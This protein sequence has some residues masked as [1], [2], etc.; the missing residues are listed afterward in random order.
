MDVFYLSPIDPIDIGFDER[1]E[2]VEF[3]ESHQQYCRHLTAAG[4]TATYSYFGDSH[5]Q[6][7]HP[8]GTH[9]VFEFPKTLELPYGF[10]LS[11]PLL[12]YL[13][14]RRPDIVHVHSLTAHSILP[15]VLV[16][17][18]LRLPLVLQHHGDT[19]GSKR[20]WVQI[21]SLKPFL[22]TLPSALLSVNKQSVDQ[23]KE[24]ELRNVKFL[25]NGVDVE[26]YAPEGDDGTRAELGVP[27]D[28]THLLYV[29]RLTDKKGVEYLL[30]AFEEILDTDGDVVLDIIFGG[31]DKQTLERVERVVAERSLSG[32]VRLV[33]R[34]DN[35]TL[36]RYYH[37]AD[38]CVQPSLREGFGVVPLEAMASQ[39]PVVITEAHIEAGHTVVD[40]EHGRIVS[41]GSVDEL[42]AAL[43]SM[44]AEEGGRE[45]MGESA[46]DLVVE[47]YSWSEITNSLVDTYRSLLR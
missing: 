27:L 11:V 4:H 20:Q 2:F 47:R 31:Y 9:R 44:I 41:S 14:L 35:E 3:A 40:G 37:S 42:V 43:E 24:I 25:P 21:R 8:N 15:I 32:S 22:R 17:W 39:T 23:F 6:Y 16:C 19:P 18:T 30:G 26:E 5:R 1:D 33:E 13:V 10:K 45:E 28:C 29:G 7:T 12:R 34:V 46:R 36:R 38:V